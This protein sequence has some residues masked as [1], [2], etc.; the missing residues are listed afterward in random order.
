V[1]EHLWFKA[2]QNMAVRERARLIKLKRITFRALPNVM[3][4]VDGV[5]KFPSLKGV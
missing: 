3:I 4:L 2:E 5:W 1:N